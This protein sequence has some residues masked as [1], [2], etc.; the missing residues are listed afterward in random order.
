M[1]RVL[2][3][4]AAQVWFSGGCAQ[5]QTQHTPKAAPPPEAAGFPFSRRRK[6]KGD[7]K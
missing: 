4:A 1:R 3:A 2:V 5:N 7:L 6:A